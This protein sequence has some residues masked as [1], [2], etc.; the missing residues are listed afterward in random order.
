MLYELSNIRVPYEIRHLKIGDYTWICRERSTKKEL[1]LPYIV[2]RK[3]MDDFGS[4]IKDGRFHEQKFRLKQCGLQNLI[5]L[6][7]SY[8][9]NNHTGL[10]MTTLQQAATNTLVQDGFTVKFTDDL[11]S[12]AEYL[13]CLS[14]LLIK[15][16]KVD[17]FLPYFFLFYALDFR[18][19]RLSLVQ[20]TIFKRR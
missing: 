8:G 5:Y 16:Y 14:G 20:K 10:P 6:V 18:I 13:S 19:K 17:I 11:R 15:T 1:V 9:Q 12:T 4:S 2:E 3:R 7:E